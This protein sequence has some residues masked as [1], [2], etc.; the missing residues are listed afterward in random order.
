MKIIALKGIQNSGKTS[1]INILYSLLLNNG[2]K[3]IPNKFK[4]LENNDFID[5]LE[6]PSLSVIIGIV[7]QGDYI[8]GKFSVRRHLEYLESCD[9]DITICSCTTGKEKTK[10]ITFIEAYDHVFISKTQ[11]PSK[12]KERIAN[13]DDAIKLLTQIH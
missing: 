7:S 5:V 10:I 12:D 13:F 1:T 11:S 9:C 8:N 4:Y 2:A 3:Q 6:Y